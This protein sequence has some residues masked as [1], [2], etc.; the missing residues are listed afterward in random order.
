MPDE[1]VVFWGQRPVAVLCYLIVQI[2][3]HGEK[4][5]A[6]DAAVERVCR[7]DV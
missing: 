5:I 4:S 1:R 3:V 6:E 7:A 2:F